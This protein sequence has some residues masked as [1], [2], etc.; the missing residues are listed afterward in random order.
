M[1]TGLWTSYMPRTVAAAYTPITA[2]ATG[3][4]TRLSSC[5]TQKG[6]AMT[7][8][9]SL[10][11]TLLATAT[12]TS[13]QVVQATVSMISGQGTELEVSPGNG[14]SLIWTITAQ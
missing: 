7:L 13:S 3:L 9:A 2:T 4:S 11:P 6:A 1:R 12:L 14:L 8:M 5:L 10:F